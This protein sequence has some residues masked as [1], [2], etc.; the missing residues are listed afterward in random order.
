ME[1]PI[2]PV[3]FQ[4]RFW[5]LPDRRVS[6]QDAE[7]L[8]ERGLKVRIGPD[9]YAV[10]SVKELEMLDHLASSQPPPGIEV[11]QK[12]PQP[13][14]TYRD[15]TATLE[16]LEE[17]ETRS[18]F[19]ESLSGQ[20]EAGHSVEE[21]TESLKTLVA[22]SVRGRKL[23]QS[24]LALALKA[25]L[26]P[27]VSGLM[28][29]MVQQ[30]FHLEPT[31]KLSA[32]GKTREGEEA[33]RGLLSDVRGC[34][35]R[36]ETMEEL[37]EAYDQLRG[38]GLEHNQALRQLEPLRGSLGILGQ[39]K[40]DE[41]EVRDYI[42]YYL[43]HLAAQ[44]EL[45]QLSQEFVSSGYPLS[46]VRRFCDRLARPA[47]ATTVGQAVEDFQNLGLV[48][49]RGLTSFFE[50]KLQVLDMLER[51]SESGGRDEALEQVQQLMRSLPKWRP[52]G[53]ESKEVS[54]LLQAY[55]QAT[56]EQAKA[57][58]GM[59]ERGFSLER[60]LS[61]HSMLQQEVEGYSYEQKAETFFALSPGRGLTRYYAVKTFLYHR[62]QSQPDKRQDLDTLS[63]F[64][65]N[66][67][68][69][70]EERPVEAA[71][72][73]ADLVDK[74]SQDPEVWELIQ[75]MAGQGFHMKRTLDFINLVTAPGEL[76]KSERCQALKVVITGWN[77]LREYASREELLLAYQRAR[78]EG[79]GPDQG[80]EQLKD[81][82]AVMR[83][84]SSKESQPP[85][86]E[87]S[88]LLMR[89]ANTQIMTRM[90]QAGF[91]PS[92]MVDFAKELTSEEKRQAFSELGLL[93]RRPPFTSYAVKTAALATYQARRELG[94]GHQESV[95]LTRQWLERFAVEQTPTEAVVTFLEECQLL[96]SQP[97]LSRR[98]ATSALPLAD[99]PKWL[100]RWTEL[101]ENQRVHL[102]EVGL[103]EGNGLF[104]T[105][106]YREAYFEAF[107][108]A[109]G[110]PKMVPH[111]E[112]CHRSM[113]ERQMSGEAATEFL[114][115]PFRAGLELDQQ[116]LVLTED[117]DSVTIDG[118]ILP[119]ND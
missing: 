19:F 98:L 94:Q 68:N 29:M 28:T 14:E 67:R 41:A 43:E 62:F 116:A 39:D 75:E 97:E 52:E 79:V 44:P 71:R 100:A 26:S 30:N 64:L 77:L 110:K 61:Y 35:R 58:D 36:Y 53:F 99:L 47:A 114:K 48:R 69:D 105:S 113:E 21:V 8:L 51:K 34:L 38:R 42:G 10:E 111:L 45:R 12:L 95:E 1:Q 96:L 89:P 6:R 23:S 112:A 70:Q 57:L 31:L 85:I 101:A 60:A 15:L 63:N 90:A 13:F 7:S 87:L 106:D 18:R 118:V 5:F 88:R 74:F 27:Q 49:G 50:T 76:A 82:A 80:L 117:V 81:A 93:D 4:E 56:P 59:G 119:R 3:L 83:Q 17:P 32:R 73:A 107:M 103:F 84:I 54:A 40:A 25:T 72:I 78:E 108:A 66:H 11:L 37:L 115:G 55:G 16:D 92:K 33:T 86:K 102:D 20:V 2:Q 46:E 22:T 9:T 104:A 109:S 24:Q 91:H 65:A